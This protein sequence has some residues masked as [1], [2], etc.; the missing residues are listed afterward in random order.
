MKWCENILDEEEFIIKDKYISLY[1]MISIFYRI[2]EI[3]QT[4][5]GQAGD[6]SDNVFCTHVN[7]ILLDIDE[8]NIFQFLYFIIS[9]QP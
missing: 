9:L 8:K 6:I 2:I 5:D 3:I 1:Q 4:D 7:I